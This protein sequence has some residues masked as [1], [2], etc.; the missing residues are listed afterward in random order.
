EKE[1]VWL[2][3]LI[4]PG[5]FDGRHE[6]RLEETEVGETLFI[7]SESFSG[8]L[9]PFMKKDLDTKAKKGFENM[10]KAIKS[11]AEKKV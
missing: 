8:I 5:I 7:H 4:I 6:F 9:V 10:N 1:L 3:R 11:L 2:G